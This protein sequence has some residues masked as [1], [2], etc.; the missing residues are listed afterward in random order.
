MIIKSIRTIKL[1]IVIGNLLSLISGFLLA[2][3]TTKIINIK[4]LIYTI[5]GMFFLLVS[6]CLLNNYIDRDI[7][8][9]MDRTKDRLFINNKIL[10]LLLLWM[11]ILLATLGL[12]ILVITNNLLVLILSLLGTIIYILFYSIYLKRNS[13]YS[14]LIGSLSGAMPPV[15]GYCSILNFNYESLILMLIFIT[16]Q[17]PHSY[18]LSIMYINDYKKANIPV[19][20]LYYGYLTTRKYII[21]FIILYILLIFLLG[22]LTNS[23]MY[24]IITNLP[25]MIVW[26]YISLGINNINNWAKK[27]FILSIINI[28][29]FNLSILSYYKV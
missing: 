29:I 7:D 13:L 27:I 3:R 22:I 1:K 9:I 16:W 14:I 18:A 15:I 26:L 28:N 25:A 6:N 20:P 21:I 8:I 2:S 19:L 24:F 12:I 23:N 4:L 11:S 5:L 17:I 10:S